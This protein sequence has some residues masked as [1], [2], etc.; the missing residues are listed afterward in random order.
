[1][2]CYYTMA[3]TITSQPVSTIRCFTKRYRLLLHTKRYFWMWYCIA[4]KVDEKYAKRKYL[5]VTDPVTT[6]GVEWDDIIA[7]GAAHDP[8][9]LVDKVCI[10]AHLRIEL[11]STVHRQTLYSIQKHL[12]VFVDGSTRG[13]VCGRCCRDCFCRHLHNNT[14]SRA[15]ESHR[16]CTQNTERYPR[17]LVS[18][19]KTH[20][21]MQNNTISYSKT[22]YRMSRES[23]PS[24]EDHLRRRRRRSCWGSWLLRNT[25]Q[26]TAE[27]A[28]WEVHHTVE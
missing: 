3:Q 27:T 14:V 19:T 12:I 1:M 8:D 18:Y 21:S 23:K 15:E 11:H 22:L 16:R 4:V 20:S 5:P 7:D 17:K 25:R 28:W 10:I 2:C 13:R 9:S 24:R 26:N 6:D